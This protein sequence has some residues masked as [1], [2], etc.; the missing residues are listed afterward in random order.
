MPSR[1]STQCQN[2]FTLVLDLSSGRSERFGTR[3]REREDGKEEGK[4]KMKMMMMMI[5]MTMMMRMTM[6]KKRRRKKESWERDVY[7]QLRGSGVESR[8]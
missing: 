6:M 5:R 2:F 3:I 4:N 7:V 8:V 1:V